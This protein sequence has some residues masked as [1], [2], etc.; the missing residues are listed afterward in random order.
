MTDRAGTL[1]EEGLIGN[2]IDTGKLQCWNFGGDWLNCEVLP[3]G[4]IVLCCMDW[5]MKHVLG[6]MYVQSFEEIMEG[7]ELAKVKDGMAGDSSID[8]L[9][10]RCSYARSVD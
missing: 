10:R 1:Q 4:T 3:D 5:E 9:C 7:Q 6:N 2:R 8:I